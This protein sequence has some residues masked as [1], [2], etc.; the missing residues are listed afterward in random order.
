MKIRFTKSQL[1]NLIFEPAME[2]PWNP[3]VALDFLWDLSQCLSAANIPHWITYGSLLGLVRQNALLESDNDIDIAIAPDVLPETLCAAL[4]AGGHT[5]RKIR[6]RDEL[7]IAICTQRNGILADLYML[8]RQDGLLV[9]YEGNKRVRL[10]MSHPQMAVTEKSFNGKAFP[11][12]I[13][14]EAYLAHIYG[15]QWR[16]PAR[17]WSWKYS[18][19]NRSA[20]E[21]SSIRGL[22]KF[23]KGWLLWKRGN[24]TKDCTIVNDST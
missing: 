11:V 17:N 23:A 22:W 19:F 16:L 1:Q 7:V 4:L 2:G 12:P 9:D 14:S 10:V 3:Q 13:H 20:I 8:S 18:S 5:I 15:P 24:C 6:K 21:V